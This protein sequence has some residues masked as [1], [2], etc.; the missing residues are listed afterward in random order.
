VPL[1]RYPASQLADNCPPAASA[2]AWR[3]ARDR[4]SAP[5][6]Q[7]DTCTSIRVAVTPSGRGA[8]WVCA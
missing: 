2:G 4:L 6:Q 3:A 5:A 1:W 8:G 7:G